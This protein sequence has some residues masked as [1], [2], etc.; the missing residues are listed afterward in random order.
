MIAVHIIVA[1]LI[2]LVSGLG[3]GGGGLFA[4]YLAIFTDIPQLSVQG[5]NLLFFLFCAGASVAVQIFRRKINLVAVCIMASLGL[6]G[7][8]IGTLF[9]NLLPEELLRRIFGIMLTATGIVSFK[10]SMKEK[11]SE[12]RSTEDIRK[13]ENATDTEGKG[14]E[15]NTDVGK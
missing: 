1:L 9:T 10:R 5:F 11:Y 2:A 6:V 3:V 4:T 12:K 8:L 13:D 14:D 7:A 15:K